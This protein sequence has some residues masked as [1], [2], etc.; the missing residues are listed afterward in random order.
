MLKNNNKIFAYKIELQLDPYLVALF[1]LCYDI[2]LKLENVTDNGVDVKYAVSLFSDSFYEMLEM[3]KDYYLSKYDKNGYTFTRDEFFSN[4]A[5]NLNSYYLRS[6]EF[7]N[8]LKT[9]EFLYCLKDSF[10]IYSTLPEKNKVVRHLNSK[11]KEIDVIGFIVGGINEDKLR[12]SIKSIPTIYNL[13]NKTGQFI[14]VVGEE[15]LKPQLLY[16]KTEWLNN[17]LL[18]TIE[19]D[20]DDIWI[21]YEHELLKSSIKFDLKN[22]E[23]LIVVDKASNGKVIGLKVNDYILLKYDVDCKNYIKEEYSNQYLWKLLKENYFRQRKKTFS[24]SSELIQ[25]FKANSKEEPFNKLL[26]N[27]K[28][29]LYID[30]SVKIEKDYQD[31]FE[32]FIVIKDLKDL[33]DLNF[34]LP[35]ANIERE[36]LGIYTKQKIDKK[37]NLLHFFRHKDD[38]FT[39]DFVN[40][41]PQPQKKEKVYILKAELAFYLIEKYFE[42][43]TEELLLEL[44]V[45]YVSNVELCI[46]EE[47]KVEFDFLIFVN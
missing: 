10:C 6:D 29:N 40:S 42:D 1:N 23:Y 20:I 27:L 4:L 21:N 44:K 9:K 37:Y 26:C 32:E 35:D 22:D 18:K 34:F 3:D 30:R 45:D 33:S 41:M 2:S 12:D 28:H 36:I 31:F 7:L 24:Y 14:K 5:T 46:D 16:I 43:I 25:N 47:S 15:N 38:G 19:V 11:F 17:D 8:K 13:I 39:E